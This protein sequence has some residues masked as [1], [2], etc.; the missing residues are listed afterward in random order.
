[1]EFFIKYQW[2]DD[3]G[4]KHNDVW[5]VNGFLYYIFH[6]RI[7]N[8]FFSSVQKYSST[9]VKKRLWKMIITWQIRFM[10]PYTNK[11]K[12]HFHCWDKTNI[13]SFFE[14]CMNEERSLKL[15]LFEEKK[16][17]RITAIQ[18]GDHRPSNL[19]SHVHLVH[20]TMIIQPIQW[21]S[22]NHTPIQCPYNLT[23]QAVCNDPLVIF[24]W[25]K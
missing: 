4:A 9:F 17:K 7:N 12:S 18:E 20:S 1:M 8:I 22:I 24:F 3:S 5:M 6:H 16:I 25:I 14:W 19:F 11:K 10:H 2:I 21:Y 13:E 23:I 15:I